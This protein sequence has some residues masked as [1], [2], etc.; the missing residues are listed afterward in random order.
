M[1]VGKLPPEVLSMAKSSCGPHTDLA[2]NDA[3]RVTRCPCGTVHVTL[4]GSGVTVR[5]SAETFRNSMIGLR[6]AAER[7]EQ[8]AEV[9]PT[10]TGTTSIN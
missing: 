1:G 10:G 4:L 5:M 8:P 3:V 7:L 6:A 9:R 2:S